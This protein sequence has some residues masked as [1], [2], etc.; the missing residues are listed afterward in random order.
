MKNYNRRN[1]FEKIS[2]GLFGL[3]IM[4]F[5]GFKTFKKIRITQKIKIT[6]H[7]EAIKRIK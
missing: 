6:E 5:F 3:S 1:F 2:I 4:N 7:K